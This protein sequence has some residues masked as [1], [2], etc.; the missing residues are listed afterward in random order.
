VL[1]P[2]IPDCRGLGV[3]AGLGIGAALI[4]VQPENDRDIRSAATHVAQELRAIAFDHRQIDATMP[5]DE[6]Q[7]GVAKASY[8]GQ[9]VGHDDQLANERWA[10]GSRSVCGTIEFS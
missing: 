5:T 4:A 9:A 6:P 1:T 8:G 10:N 7:Q 2:D 3:A